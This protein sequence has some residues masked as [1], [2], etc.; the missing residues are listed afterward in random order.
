MAN[1]FL[2]FDENKTNLVTD[3]QY[4]TSTQRL[5]G[6][7]REIAVSPLHNKL[8]LQ[9]SVASSAIAQFIEDNGGTPQEDKAAFLAAFKTAFSTAATGSRRTIHGYGF[10]VSPIQWDG[11]SAPYT[12]T[13]TDPTNLV[14]LNYN[15]Y[16]LIS[17]DQTTVAA[18]MNDMAACGIL[19][20]LHPTLNNTIVMRAYNRK[21]Q[22]QLG[23][24]I[25]WANA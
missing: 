13:L 19:T 12:Y 11:T 6:V 17:P 25:I 10:T 9:T 7:Q 22:Y 20:N 21:P 1:P 23:F 15:S 24:T 3:D 18:E 5:N 16:L 2:V 4:Q 14:D 8:Y